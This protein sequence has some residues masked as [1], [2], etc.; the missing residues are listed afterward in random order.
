MRFIA[1]TVAVV[2]IPITVT[3]E[4]FVITVGDRGARLFN[5]TK[6]IA[7]TPSLWAHPDLEPCYLS[8]VQAVLGDTITFH[9]CVC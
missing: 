3:A 7:V 5:P 4:T 2:L 1:S 8:S 9:L 6:S